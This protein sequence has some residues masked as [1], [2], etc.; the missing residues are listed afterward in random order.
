MIDWDN[1]MELF[2]ALK[3]AV[4]RHLDT[5]ER[6]S[7]YCTREPGNIVDKVWVVNERDRYVKDKGVPTDAKCYGT[8]WNGAFYFKPE[9]VK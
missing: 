7:V 1:E 6:I 5:G 4:K 3:D 9:K 2:E 8:A